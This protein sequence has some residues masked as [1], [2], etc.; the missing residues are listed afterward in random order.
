MKGTC[1]TITFGRL[2]LLLALFLLLKKTKTRKKS[3]C[4]D[5]E[6]ETNKQTKQAQKNRFACEVRTTVHTHTHL[7]TYITFVFELVLI[8][9]K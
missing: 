1:L 2:L 8:K 4:D 5:I 3:Y 7:F 6:E 9:K